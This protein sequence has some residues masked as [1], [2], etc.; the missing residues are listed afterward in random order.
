MKIEKN[1]IDYG[2]YIDH[3]KAFLISIDKEVHEETLDNDEEGFDT[4]IFTEEQSNQ[5]RNN[6][7]LKK[8]CKNI[9]TRLRQVHRVFIFG[10]SEAKYELQKEILATKSIMLEGRE[11]LATT[12]KMTMKEAKSFALKHF[13]TTISH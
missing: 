3:K 8:F 9:I 5:N 7:I 6:E 12:D 1:Y 2:I 10:P 13:N 4:R 11:E